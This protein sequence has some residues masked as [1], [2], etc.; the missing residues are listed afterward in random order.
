MKML[1]R[2]ALR[3]RARPAFIAWC[4]SVVVEDAGELEV[5]KSQLEQTGSIY[6]IPEANCEQDFIDAV[7]THA[8]DIL[9]NELNAWCI[10]L[11]F[12][13]EKL[14]AELLEQ[15][16]AIGTELMSFDLASEPLLVADTQ[17]LADEGELVEIF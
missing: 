9:K 7:L 6:L 2:S 14:D 10:D 13:P 17:Q 8:P 4:A 1:N 11:S 12:W 15:W 3:L 16:F 5:L